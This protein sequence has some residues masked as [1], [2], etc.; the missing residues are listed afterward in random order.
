MIVSEELQLIWERQE[1]LRQEAESIAWE[2]GAPACAEL[3][4]G[5]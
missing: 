4:I 5:L 1:I 3:V 2:A